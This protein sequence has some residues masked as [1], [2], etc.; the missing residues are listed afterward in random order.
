MIL[1]GILIVTGFIASAQWFH[2]FR[3]HRQLIITE[4]LLNSILQQLSINKFDCVKMVEEKPRTIRSSK[5]SATGAHLSEEHKE[6]LRKA[7]NDYWAKRRAAEAAQKKSD[8]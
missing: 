6:K 1:T 5:I 8:G 4:M 2:T 3:L 7:R